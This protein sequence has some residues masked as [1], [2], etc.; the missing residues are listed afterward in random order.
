MGEN[1]TTIS[2]YNKV[3]L[4]WDIWLHQSALHY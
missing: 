3:E 4:T 2:S 1:Y